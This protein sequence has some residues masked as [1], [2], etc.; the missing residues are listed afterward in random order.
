MRASSHLPSLPSLASHNASHRHGGRVLVNV[1]Y[2]SHMMRVSRSRSKHAMRF[3]STC[4]L[5]GNLYTCVRRGGPR[6]GRGPL[7]LSYM[8]LRAQEQCPLVLRVLSGV[9]RLRYMCVWRRGGKVLIRGF[10]LGGR[11]RYLRLSVWGRFGAFRG[12]RSPLVPLTPP[13]L[14]GAARYKGGSFIGF[15]PTAWIRHVCGRGLCAPCGV[16]GPHRDSTTWVC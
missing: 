6:R 3:R 8:L 12:V 14:T 1:D 16:P 4:S 2:G 13:N 10:S 5:N 7:I 11:S 9:Q 15:D